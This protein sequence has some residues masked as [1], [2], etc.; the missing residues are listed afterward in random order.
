MADKYITEEE[1][2]RLNELE[3]LDERNDAEDRELERLRKKDVK[4]EVPSGT[5]T[6]KV[7]ANQPGATD[8]DK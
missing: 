4:T 2:A 1:K 8:T 7:E 6:Q 3:G 5:T